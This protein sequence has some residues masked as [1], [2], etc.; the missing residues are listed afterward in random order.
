MIVGIFGATQSGHFLAQLL[1]RHPR[2]TKVYHYQTSADSIFAAGLTKYESIIRGN[3][4]KF[5]DSIRSCNLIITM[6]VNSQLDKSLQMLLKSIPALKLVPN[7]E[8][9]L[10]EDSKIESKS[11]FKKLG[12]RSP[13]YQVV[14]YENLIENFHSYKRP[15]VLKYDRDF[16]AGRQ[17]LIVNDSNYLD[18]FEEVKVHGRKKLLR[19]EENKEFIVEEYVTGKEHSLHILAKGTDWCYL[20]SARD[21]KKEFEDDQGNNVTSMGC[22]SPA[23]VLSDDVRS[24]VDKLLQYLNDNGTPYNGVMYLGVLSDKNNK[25]YILELNARPGNPEFITVLSVLDEDILDVFLSENLGKRELKRKNLSAVNIQLHD[26][27]SIYEKKAIK[28]I[29]LTGLPE[30]IQ[31]SYSYFFGLFP[32]C[33][34]TAVADDMSVAAARL[35]DYLDKENLD[36]VYRK[37]VGKLL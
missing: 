26:K 32:S 20:G 3:M 29:A 16:R 36:A 1:D 25:D 10:L 8:C 23:G 12:I 5:L 33:G 4:Q 35:Y 24:Y 13:D 2:V 9:S 37:D 14:S 22:Y 15:F 31:A 7:E 34:L 17:T 6:G 21:Y 19:E 18:I 27:K 28:E 30:G 11:L